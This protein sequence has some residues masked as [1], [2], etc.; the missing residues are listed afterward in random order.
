MR[1]SNFRMKK[2]NE[3][4]ILSEFRTIKGYDQR[5][6]KELTPTMEDYLEMI[7]R[8]CGP[9]GFVRVSQLSQRLNVRPSSASKIAEQLKREG[10]VEF[11]R[12]GVIR[13][14]EK[15]W[16]AGCYLL[17]RH[18]ILHEFLCRLNGTTDELEQVEQVEHFL[19]RE[20]VENLEKWLN[21]QN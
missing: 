16:E 13:P 17:Y 20:T 15:G 2:R 11:E 12:Y 4:K 5:H 7:C 8:H 14:T 9:G 3:E 19:S 18:E 10:Y 6:N 1:K 21:H